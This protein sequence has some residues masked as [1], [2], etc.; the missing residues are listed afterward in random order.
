MRNPRS[1]RQRYA[2]NIKRMDNKVQ[3]GTATASTVLRSPET[4]LDGLVGQG[5]LTSTSWV[6]WGI[7][8]L[9]LNAPAEA[10]VFVALIWLTLNFSSSGSVLTRLSTNGVL[11]EEIEWRGDLFNTTTAVIAVQHEMA[12]VEPEMDVF[13]QAKVAVDTEVYNPPAEV[14]GAR[15]TMTFWWS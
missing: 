13:T 10:R 9:T 6:T 14:S 7:P 5:D 4:L 15:Y 3:T 11:S 8:R 2:S 12:V 1:R